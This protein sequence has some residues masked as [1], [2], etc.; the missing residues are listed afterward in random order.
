MKRYLCVMIPARLI[1]PLLD[2]HVVF[3]RMSMVCRWCFRQAEAGA[4]ICGRPS[5]LS[6]WLAVLALDDEWTEL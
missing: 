2:Q 1:Y 3:P 4:E 5:C 6:N